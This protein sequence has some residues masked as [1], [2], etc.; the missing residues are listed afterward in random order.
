MIFED[1]FDKVIPRPDVDK[2][3]IPEEWYDEEE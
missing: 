1:E 3:E 2:D